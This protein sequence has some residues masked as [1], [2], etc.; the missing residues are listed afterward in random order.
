VASNLL[1]VKYRKTIP[2]TGLLANRNPFA[3]VF[4]VLRPQVPL[5]IAVPRR[6]RTPEGVC[7]NRQTLVLDSGCL[8]FTRLCIVVVVVHAFCLESGLVEASVDLHSE[9]KPP[10]LVG[11][12]TS[13]SWYMW[14]TTTVL[15]LCQNLMFYDQS[16]SDINQSIRRSLRKR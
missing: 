11:I 10:N 14:P 4:P 12:L 13:K 15:R 16:S 1:Q 8:T 3:C 9:G 2:T 7:R 6:M 5:P